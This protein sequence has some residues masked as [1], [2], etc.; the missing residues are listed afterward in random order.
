VKRNKNPPREIC[1]FMNS[2]SG[3]QVNIYHEQI[4]A[5]F[6]KHIQDNYSNHTVA[7]TL[8]MVN[9]KTSERFF[10]GSKDNASNVPAGTLVNK[11]LVSPNYDF[12]IVSQQS[13]K[14]SAVPNHYRV[15]FS[16]SKVEEGTLQEL[17][18]GQCF[19]YVNWTGSIKVPS[20]LQYAKKCVKF[21]SEVMGNSSN[22]KED[23]SEDIQNKLFYV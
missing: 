6:I 5:P 18:F 12:F 4:V 9:L 3:D 2:C 11:E 21:L 19:N 17:I 15:I 16:N 7:L 10:M 14:G 8:I 22:L 1:V 13:N 23:V 20:V